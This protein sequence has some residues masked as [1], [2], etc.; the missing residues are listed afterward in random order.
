MKSKMSVN[1]SRG[2]N[3]DRCKNCINFRTPAQCIKVWGKIDPEYWCELFKKKE[4]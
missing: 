2:M 4:K 3:N 1:Y